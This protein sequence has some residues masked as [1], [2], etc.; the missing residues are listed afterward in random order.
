MLNLIASIQV[1][2]LSSMGVGGKILFYHLPSLLQINQQK[3]K[4]Q[5]NDQSI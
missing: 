1:G 4:N 2:I 5:S 3:F